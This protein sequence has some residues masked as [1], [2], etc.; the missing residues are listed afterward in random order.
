LLYVKTQLNELAAH[1][2]QLRINKLSFIYKKNENDDCP[3]CPPGNCRRTD[4][5]N[6]VRKVIISGFFRTLL[7]ENDK[8]RVTVFIQKYWRKATET[9]FR[10]KFRNKY[11]KFPTKKAKVE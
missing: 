6:V 1:T 11:F 9:N 7:I 10:N 4:K 3:V 2:N 5:K 8:I